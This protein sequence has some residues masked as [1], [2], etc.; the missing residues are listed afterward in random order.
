MM[1]HDETFAQFF[2]VKHTENIAQ[3]DHSQC[4]D[5]QKNSIGMTSIP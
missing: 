3:L 5:V 4:E 1:E 2:F